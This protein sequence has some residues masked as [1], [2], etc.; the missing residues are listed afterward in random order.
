MQKIPSMLISMIM[1]C[2]PAIAETRKFNTNMS[3][4]I[5][6]NGLLNK[7]HFH[8]CGPSADECANFDVRR[9]SN[10][11]IQ[12]HGEG[13]QTDHEGYYYCCNGSTTKTGYY[14]K[15]TK[16]TWETT[17]TITLQL[18]NG[19][20]TYQ[21]KTNVC[22]EVVEDTPCTVAI[23]CPDNLIIRNGACVKPCGENDGNIAYES[24]TSNTCVECPTN[25]T[26]GIDKDK[27]CTKC[28]SDL[29]H[30]YRAD[31]NESGRSA[32]VIF[33]RNRPSV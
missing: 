23:S 8:F 27:I 9:R 18:G 25:A 1:L 13:F 11:T 28:N 31:K 33:L 20:C 17:K 21:K 12:R 16:G 29:C 5:D 3:C 2:N 32:A 14:V 19:K 10:V 26:Q 24:A 7:R 6:T 15:G 22:G 4:H 30:S